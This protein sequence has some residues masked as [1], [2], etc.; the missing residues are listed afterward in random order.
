MSKRFWTVLGIVLLILTI[1]FLFLTMSVDDMP[2][3]IGKYGRNVIHP[4]NPYRIWI[5]ICGI[6]SFVSFLIAN[7]DSK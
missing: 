7:D 6:G 1:I 2:Y 4:S 3:A 5:W